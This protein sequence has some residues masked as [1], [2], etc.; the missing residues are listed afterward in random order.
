[1][2]D[3]LD[4]V[5]LALRI[6]C[7][8]ILY[9]FVF[10]AMRVAVRGLR[11]GP[12]AQPSLHLLVLDAG[13]SDLRPGQ[14]LEVADGAVL[15]RIGQA[16]VI[17]ADPAVSSAHARISRAGAGWLVTDLGS[18]NGTRVNEALVAAQTALG[19]GDVLGLGNVRL[20]VVGR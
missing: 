4:V 8:A 3:W 19:P 15:G 9:V 12:E 1:V 7:V 11:A 16:E 17:L 10:L 6:A 14:L 2:V 5:I 13:E 18:T 20:Q